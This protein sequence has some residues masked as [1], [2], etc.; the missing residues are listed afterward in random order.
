MSTHA[1]YILRDG[2]VIV[3]QD[4]SEI[5]FETRGIIQ[6]LVGES[7]SEGSITNDCCYIFTAAGE[8]PGLCKT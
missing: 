6:C 8:L 1:T 4:N 5:A 2:H 3:I 7:S